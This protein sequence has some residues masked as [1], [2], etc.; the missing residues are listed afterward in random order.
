MPSAS[1]SGDAAGEATVRGPAAGPP[2]PAVPPPAAH[3]GETGRHDGRRD[4]ARDAVLGS[5]PYMAPEQ[6]LM[7]DTDARTDVYSFGLILLELLTGEAARPGFTLEALLDAARRGHVGESLA[8]LE[9]SD[10]G[11]RLVGLCVRCVQYR[12]ADRPADAAAVLADLNRLSA[13]D[14]ATGRRVWNLGDA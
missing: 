12:P 10:A 9:H 3:R 4:T 11:A 6:A 13:R 5:A 14:G 7:R 2:A 8:R 1:A